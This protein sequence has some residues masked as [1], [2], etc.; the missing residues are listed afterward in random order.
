VDV[1]YDLSDIASRNVIGMQIYDSEDCSFLN[2]DCRRRKGIEGEGQK[3][4]AYEKISK[5]QRGRK[6]TPQTTER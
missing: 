3:E 5:I 6:E 1:G 4:E 2:C